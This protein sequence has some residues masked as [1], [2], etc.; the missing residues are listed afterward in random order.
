MQEVRD[1]ANQRAVGVRNMV[2]VPSEA[3]R[4]LERGAAEKGLAA[5]QEALGRLATSVAQS[6]DA[7]SGRSLLAAL[8]SAEQAYSPVALAIVKLAER[9]E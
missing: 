1:A 9:R 5:V 7:T 6:A 4:D 2:L 3:E 8:T